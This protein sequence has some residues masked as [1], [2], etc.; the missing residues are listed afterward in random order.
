MKAINKQIGK[1]CSTN[2]VFHKKIE[3]MPELFNVLKTEKSIFWNHR[4]FP[5]AVIIQQKLI[6]IERALEYG[7][8]WQ[9]KP[10]PC[11]EKCS[12]ESIPSFE[13]TLKSFRM[14]TIEPETFNEWT[15]DNLLSM[16]EMKLNVFRIYNAKNPEMILM[17]TKMVDFIKRIN[18]QTMK[19]QPEPISLEIYGIKI[20][21]S[22][23][24]SETFITII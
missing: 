4:P 22:T 5:T 14:E 19:N 11:D 16:I 20:V 24:V 21:R 8:F 12:N 18:K 2:Y 1:P 15:F 7:H 9:I 23:D 17:N 3:T 10:K 6:T 13:K